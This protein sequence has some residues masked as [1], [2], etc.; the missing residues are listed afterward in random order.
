MGLTHAK[1]FFYHLHNSTK[2]W[3]DLFQLQVRHRLEPARLVHR[4]PMENFGVRCSSS[5]RALPATSTPHLRYTVIPRQQMHL[6]YNA[7]CSSPLLFRN[8]HCMKISKYDGAWQISVVKRVVT[9]LG[10]ARE[11][12]VLLTWII[13]DRSVMQED[14]CLS[15]HMRTAKNV[16]LRSNATQFLLLTKF[17]RQIKPTLG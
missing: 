9:I 15:L 5:W 14:Y 1:S 7:L 2:N 4:E 12:V 8:N 3:D 10:R 11:G 17:N 6:Q 16:K 13:D